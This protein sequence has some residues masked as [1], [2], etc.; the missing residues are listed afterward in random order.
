MG[1]KRRR[2]DEEI[3]AGLVKA[4]QDILEKEDQKIEELKGTL[5]STKS[6]SIVLLDAAV[7]LSYHTRW[8]AASLELIETLYFEIFG[9]K[10][11]GADLLNL[12]LFEE[13]NK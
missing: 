5:S 4:Y 12:N 13:V 7:N 8:K 6:S 2:S 9:E 3:R 11:G 10:F 1:R